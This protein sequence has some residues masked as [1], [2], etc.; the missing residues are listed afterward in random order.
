MITWCAGLA[1][2]HASQPSEVVENIHGVSQS[3]HV[4]IGFA[5]VSRQLYVIPVKLV[6]AVI[7]DCF[8]TPPGKS[9]VMQLAFESPAVTVPPPDP[10]PAIDGLLALD[11]EL[12]ADRLWVDELLM[13]NFNGSF[14][15]ANELGI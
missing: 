5:N 10:S 3:A 14:T 2:S 7:V 9:R 12:L 15:I 8:N 11:G 1:A 6:A 4:G 13:A